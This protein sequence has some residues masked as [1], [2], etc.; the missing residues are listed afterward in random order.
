M[1]LVKQGA[2]IYHRPEVGREGFRRGRNCPYIT[3]EFGDWEGVEFWHHPRFIDPI[4]RDFQL[5]P[6][7]ERSSPA[8]IFSMM[9]PATST[10]VVV[11]MPSRPGE[12]FTSIT[13]GPRLERSRSTPAMSSP[14][15]RADF[16]TIFSSSLLSL[17][18]VAVAPR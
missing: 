10:P 6:F 2:D 8:S 3:R 11:S 16:R 7:T 14:I 12:A 4:G 18:T 15:N 9:A 1:T 13:K 17:V 5:R